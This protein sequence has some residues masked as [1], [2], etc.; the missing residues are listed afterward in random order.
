MAWTDPAAHVWTTGEVV[1][2]AN[3][4]T[5]IK[6]N[7]LALYNAPS[8]RAFNSAAITVATGTDTVLNLNSERHDNEAMHS[9]ATL[10]SRLTVPVG[11]GGV[12]S[13]SAHVRFAGH[14][15]GYR[16]LYLRASGTTRIA[17]QDTPSIGANPMALS[18]GTQFKLAAGAYVEM[19]VW[20]NRSDG[21]NSNNL[22]VDS[23]AQY[24]PELAMTWLSA[25]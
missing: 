20:H 4:N 12:Y 19:L 5:Y 7:L 18:L 16:A 13:I 23:T 10:T 25:G 24:S 14:S 3:L 1:T 15:G 17:Q 22:N 2:A 6:D 9:T 8:V 11:W 21:V